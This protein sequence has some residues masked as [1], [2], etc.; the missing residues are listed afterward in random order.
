[1][2]E[3]AES[4]QKVRRRD[5]VFGVISQGT[6]CY[7]KNSIRAYM[8]NS[9]RGRAIGDKCPAVE[10]KALANEV[11]VVFA[12]SSGFARPRW[13]RKHTRPRWLRKHNGADK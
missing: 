11:S 1:M 4:I 12:L 6:T 9:E 3:A 10:S 8:P 13:L 5:G 7:S 2:I